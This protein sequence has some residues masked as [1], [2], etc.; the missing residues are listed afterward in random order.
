MHQAVSNLLKLV[1]LTQHSA[2]ENLQVIAHIDS[3][4]FLSTVSFKYFH[5]NVPQFV[6]PF[7][8]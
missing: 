2:F 1:Y 6:Q 3:L 8:H 5:C 7:M 4:L